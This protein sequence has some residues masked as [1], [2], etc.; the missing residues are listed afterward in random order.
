M[1]RDNDEVQGAILI[2]DR[3]TLHK[4]HKLEPN[5][6]PY[7]HTDTIFHDEA[8]EEVREDITIAQHLLGF[9]LATP[10][11]RAPKKPWLNPKRRK[12]L[13]K[14]YET[15]VAARLRGLTSQPTIPMTSP[16]VPVAT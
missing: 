8:E 12:G 13:Y 9:V 1:P 5:P 14:A 15:Q 10:D 11:P 4:Q 6:E 3:R 16:T 2:L 7:W